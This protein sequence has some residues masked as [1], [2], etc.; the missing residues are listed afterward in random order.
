MSW[1][2][3][4]CVMRGSM[5]CQPGRVREAGAVRLGGSGV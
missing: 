4:P 1:I 5:S 2:L 3:E